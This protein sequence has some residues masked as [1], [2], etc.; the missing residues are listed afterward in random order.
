MSHKHPCSDHHGEG[1]TVL[2]LPIP[3]ALKEEWKVAITRRH[4]LRRAGSTLGG[5]GLAHLLGSDSAFAAG[6]GQGSL[7]APHNTGKAK[8]VIWLFMAGG[9]PHQDMWDYKPRLEEFNG[10]D[11]PKEILGADFKPSGMTAGS[12]R[13]TVKASPFKFKQYGQC[14]RFVSDALPWTAKCVDD[15]ATI[16]SMYSDAINHEPA[17][18]L[19]NTAAMF[20][21]RP[22]LGAWISYGLGSMNSNLPSF[23]VLNSIVLPGLPVQPVTPRLWSSSFLPT[24]HAGVALRADADPVLY[25]RDP[26]GMDRALRRNLLDGIAE[27]NERTFRALGDTETHARIAQYEMAFNMQMSV[28]ELADFSDEPESTW[29]LYGPDAKKP[30]SFTYN[31]LMARRMAERGVRFTQI[32][33]RGWDFHGGLSGGMNALCGATDRACY[34]L[35][36][37]LKRRGLLDDTLVIWGGEFGRTTYSQGGDGRDHHAKCFTNWMAGGG[38]KGGTSHGQTDDFA[39]NLLDV[40]D[41]VHPRDLIATAC[42][43]LGIESDRLTKRVLGVDLKPTGVEHGKLIKSILL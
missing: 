2:N 40:G 13:F 19:M 34:A 8:R 21:G 20:P 17:I 42:H 9:P 11:I 18:M 38:I 12:S 10:Q 3:S 16:H 33:Q 26:E 15:I 31:C 14:G 37:D 6:Q 22:A 36:T 24:E 5:L 43:T 29:E 32:Y 30:G 25:L 39:F 35:I 41:K 7:G 1:P 23:V 28:P 4:F 27:H